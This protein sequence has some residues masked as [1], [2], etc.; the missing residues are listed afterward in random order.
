MIRAVLFDLDDTLVDHQHANRAALAGVRERFAALQ[1]R[2]LDD[3]VAENQRIL[4]D[5][6][7][8]VAVGRRDVADAR[9]ERYR[10]LFAFA[11]EPNGR[12]AAAA[13]LHRRVYQAN[14]RRVEGAL[15]LVTLL[16]ARL[17]VAIVT[18]HTVA[19][20]Q[21]KLATFGFAPMVH[22]LVTSEEVGAAKPDP[23]IFRAALTRVECEAHEAVM[24]GDAWYQ[25]IVGATGAG[26]RAL[27]LNRQGLAHPD[28][29]LALQI[30]ALHPAEHIAALVT[31]DHVLLNRPA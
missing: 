25:D 16:A 1:A 23:R 28:S 27:W 18:N 6:H 20:Q 15:E 2:A 31:P 5:I 13:E 3:L 14:R 10:R 19:E 22:A 12:A 9:I 29:S 21:E 4:D 17:R 30:A 8:D 11:G 24:I 7:E 26:I